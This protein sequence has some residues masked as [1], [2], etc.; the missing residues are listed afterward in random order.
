MVQSIERALD[1]LEALASADDGLSLTHLRERVDLPLGTLHRL[2]ATLNERG[3]ATQDAATRHYGPG[4]KL[5]EIAASALN[6]RQF[7]LQRIAR[8]F[9]QE[10]TAVAGETSNL[11]IYQGDEAV[12]IEQVSG[13]QLVRMFTEVGQRVPLYCTGAGKAILLG[14][15][16]AQLDAYLA[17]RQLARIT[18]H[19]LTSAEQLRAEIER[20]RERGFAIDDEEREEGVRCAAAPV[21]DHIGNCVAAISVSGP[22]TRLSRQQVIEIGFHVRRI[23]AAASAQ[24]GYRAPQAG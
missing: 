24:L 12:Y 21:F 7:S 2:L 1:I 6:H 3:Y 14:M 20:S 11:V 13:P 16:P 5:L 4:P 15:A 18:A 10:L 17:N 9:L 8:P 23:A 19:T 22:T